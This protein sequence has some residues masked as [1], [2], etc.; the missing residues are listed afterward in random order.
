MFFCFCWWLFFNTSKIQFESKSQRKWD[1]W[2]SISSCFSIRQRYNLKA[3][4]NRRV[5]FQNTYVVVFQ[6]VKDT[7]W[8]QITTTHISFAKGFELFFN[9]SKIQFES[10]SQLYLCFF[11]F[12]HSCFS[13][14]QRYNLKANHNR[15]F[16]FNIIRIVV[17]QYVKDTIWK[18]ITT[19]TC[20]SIHFWKL[21]FNT[22]KIQ[23]E[24]K[25]QLF[26]LRENEVLCCFSIRQRYN[27]KANHNIFC[28]CYL[29]RHGCFSIR[30]RYNLKA[31]H[32]YIREFN[33][34]FIVV[35]QYVKD[36]IW[37]QITTNAFQSV[38]CVG[39]FFNTSKIQFESKSQRQCRT[40]WTQI[41]CF[42]IRQRYNL[43]AN[44]NPALS[45]HPS[46]NV[47]FQYVK[48]TIWKQITTDMYCVKQWVWLFFNTSKIQFES[49]S[50][51]L[52][53]IYN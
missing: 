44:H 14:R 9:T 31:N 13:I 46:Q 32:N 33:N 50:Q 23:F 51:L 17:F 48:D 36:T 52:S 1:V 27:L 25:S 28:A 34:P 47:V 19:S 29:R 5:V 24:S 39:L 18:Q 4:H 8:K 30:Q 2:R 22:S 7:I 43:K 12:Q 26:P 53:C 20:S 15:V 38:H 6:Y 41:S 35:F 11:R 37:K 21:F 3:N 45:G 49:K 10:K 16:K 42:S 40:R